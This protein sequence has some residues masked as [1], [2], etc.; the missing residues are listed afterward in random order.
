[1]RMNKRKIL[2]GRYL[3]GRDRQLGF[4]KD[5][6]KIWGKH[7]K[8]HKENAWEKMVETDVVEKPVERATCEEIVE[9]C[10]T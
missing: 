7:K 4:S 3:G 8:N 1:M 6:A 5:R 2:G 10:K 9:Q